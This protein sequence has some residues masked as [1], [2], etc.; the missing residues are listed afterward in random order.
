V[1]GWVWCGLDPSTESDSSSS[2]AQ[3][4]SSNRPFSGCQEASSCRN[5]SPLPVIALCPPLPG[6][7]ILHPK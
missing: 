1:Q 2:S 5:S 6:G 7:S 4:G 3:I